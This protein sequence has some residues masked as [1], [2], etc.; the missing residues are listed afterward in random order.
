[1]PQASSAIAVIII[2]AGLISA[3]LRFAGLRFAGLRFAVD[4]L[5]EIAMKAL[6]SDPH[7]STI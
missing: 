5:R 2:S 4:K 7:E 3:G 1:M 6:D